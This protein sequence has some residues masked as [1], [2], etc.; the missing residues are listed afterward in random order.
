MRRMLLV[1]GVLLFLWNQRAEVSAQDP[2]FIGGNK[3]LRFEESPG[4]F[5]Y[6]YSCMTGREM[7]R[8]PQIAAKLNGATETAVCWPATALRAKKN[9]TSYDASPV[10]QGLI[11]T[12]AH[13]F[14]FIPNDIKNADLYADY[15]PEEIDVQHKPGEAFAFFGTKDV[16]FKFGFANFCAACE[17]GTTPPPTKD[18][19]QLDREF[20]LLRDSIRH[21]EALS[22]QVTDRAAK[23]RVE[24]RPDNQPG[25]ADIPES[26]K[27]YSDL[28]ERFAEMCPEPAK[29]CIR[30]FAA[31]EKCKSASWGTECGQRPT[32]SEACG[33][34]LQDLRKLNASGC[35]QFDQQ[36][37]SLSPDWTEV[38]KAKNKSNLPI[39]TFQPG[40]VDLQA[41]PGP[42]VPTS[43]GCSVSK[44]LERA[45]MPGLGV[46]GME[47]LGGTAALEGAVGSPYGP[48][49]IKMVAPNRVS[50][51]AGVAT[52]MLL[53]KVAP[54]Y[55][56]IAKA[57][58]VQGTVVLQATISKAGAISDLHVVDGPPLLQSAALDAVKQWQYRPFLL[59]GE[60]VEVETT[61]NVI[62]ILGDSPPSAA[63]PSSLPTGKSQP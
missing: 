44:I 28:N 43:V 34:T 19:A 37:V 29:S 51:T 30:A 3:A 16:F 4:V 40:F 63:A 14:R 41:Q 32:C 26:L 47:G 45:S 10:M 13:D 42:N 58:R 53:K 46:A 20:E 48:R 2:A 31:F 49:N 59:N 27:L 33:V 62:F 18:T 12:S 9:G 39:G 22:Q 5:H 52:G 56:P 55:P 1:L 11:V 50:I 57:A 21:F 7:M 54:E 8:L 38:A 36:G 25:V 61:I 23:V 60:P 17:S 35:V 24:I 15:R 6:L